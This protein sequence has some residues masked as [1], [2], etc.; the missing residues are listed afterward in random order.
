MVCPFMSFV[1]PTRDADIVANATAHCVGDQC[2]VWDVERKC[3]SF[4]SKPA[5][6]IQHDPNFGCTGPKE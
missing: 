4:N 2:A 3:C 6:I 1:R 5:I